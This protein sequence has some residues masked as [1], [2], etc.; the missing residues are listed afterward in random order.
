[1]G[2]TVAVGSLEDMW[3]VHERVW[4]VWL[5][6]AGAVLALG[7]GPVLSTYVCTSSLEWLV[8]GSHALFV[9]SS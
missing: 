1:M 6:V 8:L 9:P 2:A 3:N 4:M 5:W 7:I